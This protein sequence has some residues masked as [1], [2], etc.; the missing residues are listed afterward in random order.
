MDA[1]QPTPQRRQF[2]LRTFLLLTIPIAAICLVGARFHHAYEEDRRQM[3]EAYARYEKELA[4][5]QKIIAWQG[6][7]VSVYISGPQR[8]SP[9][10]GLRN[11]LPEFQW[12]SDYF[13]GSHGT[14]GM[15]SFSNS[16]VSTELLETI[17]QLE[18]P[19]IIHFYGCSFPKDVSQLNKLT[20]LAKFSVHLSKGMDQERNQNESSGERLSDD[21]FIQN[22]ML[23]VASL[24]H[25]TDVSF[26]QLPVSSEV[27]TQIGQKKTLSTL[28]LTGCQVDWNGLSTEDLE[29]W[30]GLRE[31]QL[32]GGEMNAEKTNQILG[33][34]SLKSL[35]LENL[36]IDLS[37]GATLDQL[38]NIRELKLV[39]VKIP[40]EVMR[41]ICESTTLTKLELENCQID[42]SQTN[43]LQL[44]TIL[45]DFSLAGSN[46][47]DQNLRGIDQ[48]SKLRHLEL[49]ETAIGDATLANL[50]SLPNL[51]ELYLPYTQISDEA[52]PLVLAHP[53]L[54]KIE[55]QY[56]NLTDEGIQQLAKS[57]SLR[58]I[59]LQRTKLTD[60]GLTR[61]NSVFMWHL[62][63]SGTAVTRAGVRELAENI[64]ATDIHL[65]GSWT[66]HVYVAKT[67]VVGGTEQ[68][69]TDL[70]EGLKRVEIQD[71]WR[72]CSSIYHHEDHAFS[73][74][75]C[76]ARQ[77]PIQIDFQELPTWDLTT[78]EALAAT[79]H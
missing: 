64:D 19:E 10:G 18:K 72:S 24:P 52:V 65:L 1:N 46:V 56:T 27:I 23:T 22:Q 41:S 17:S 73:S 51:S 74:C 28:K 21:A 35:S 20:T 48:L 8:S 38:E 70:N 50:T 69:L 6:I 9:G 12:H 31:L 79:L 63:V 39:G 7:S 16:S 60:K 30:E 44:L 49:S 57:K 37:Q 26:Y 76:R 42:W 3:R 4:L 43:D 59:N 71:S 45:S 58:E 61:L 40:A 67:A 62:N 68:D 47:T 55:L 66:T 36:Q 53:H 11:S 29:S 5:T 25:I 13:E 2:S 14:V 33:I 78:A 54:E 75:S 15:L 32:V 77:W 34:A